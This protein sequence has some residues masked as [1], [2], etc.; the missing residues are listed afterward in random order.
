MNTKL[1]LKAAGRLVAKVAITGAIVA[2]PVAVYAGPA[3]ADT[4]GVTDADRPYYPNY[5]N[6]DPALW[7]P[8]G[9]PNYNR[10]LQPWQQPQQ[11][12]N[13]WNPW[14]AWQWQWQQP[15][16]PTW[17]PYQQQWQPPLNQ[18]LAP[19]FNL[20]QFFSIFGS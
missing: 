12:W 4:P 17:P 10:P 19:N 5:P 11:P 3:M 18:P 16:Q 9:T 7:T 15:Q 13:Q 8:P 20:Q 2:I 1:G 14:N 6:N